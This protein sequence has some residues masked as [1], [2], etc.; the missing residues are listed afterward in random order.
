MPSIAL[1]VEPLTP[2]VGAEVSGIDLTRPLDDATLGDLKETWIRHLVLFF[3][4][5]E[6]TF[7]Q[8]K[9]LGRRFGELHIHPAAPKG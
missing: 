1:Q 3:R 2:A 4:E 6:L 5:Q 7:D 9:A 8:H